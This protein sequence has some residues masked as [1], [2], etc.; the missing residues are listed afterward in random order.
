M[1]NLVSQEIRWRESEEDTRYYLCHSHTCKHTSEHS[2]MYTAHT[3]THTHTH[4]HAWL[5]KEME[6][7]REGMCGHRDGCHFK[8]SGTFSRPWRGNSDLLT[9][10][11]AVSPMMLL[12]MTINLRELN[13]KGSHLSGDTP[14][15]WSSNTQRDLSRISGVFIVSSLVFCLFVCF[16]KN[17]GLKNLKKKKQPGIVAQAFNPTLGR[18]R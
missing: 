12:M 2:S 6:S 1:R 16:F 7:S 15:F 10:V 4:T 3:H 11:I 13:G 5:E 18:Q 9:T 14:G 8:L 17:W